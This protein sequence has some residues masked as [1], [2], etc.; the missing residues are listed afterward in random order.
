M[1]RY[2]EAS[3]HFSMTLFLLFYSTKLKILEM[4]LEFGVGWFQKKV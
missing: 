1:P 4:F 2:K 3:V